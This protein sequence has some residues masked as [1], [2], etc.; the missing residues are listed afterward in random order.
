VRLKQGK[1]TK[2]IG[3]FLHRQ[4]VSLPKAWLTALSG[5]GGWR[6]AG[7]PGATQSMSNQ[8]FETLGLV[9]LVQRYTTLQA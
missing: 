7:S 5:K 2:A 3:D 4:G 1:R 9:N 6:L 8:W